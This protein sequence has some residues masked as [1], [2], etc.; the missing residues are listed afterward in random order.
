MLLLEKGGEHCIH[1]GDRVDG[2]AKGVGSSFGEERTLGG[3]VGVHPVGSELVLGIVQMS[4]GLL[5]TT[6]N[7]SEV[8]FLD[9]SGKEWHHHLYGMYEQKRVQVG[10][11]DSKRVIQS[12]TVSYRGIQCPI[13]FYGVNNS[14]TL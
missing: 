3:D 12:H 11:I 13:K 8:H 14:H 2:F 6:L 5:R 7:D 9:K 1:G 4:S 10:E